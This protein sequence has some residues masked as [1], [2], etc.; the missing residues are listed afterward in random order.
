M[1]ELINQHLVSLDTY[2]GSSTDQVIDALAAL[3][4]R[5]G[6]ASDA[7]ALGAD[8]KAREAKTATGVP[9]GIAIPHCRSAAVTAPTLAMARLAPAVDF[10]AKDGPADLVFFIAAPEGADKD[11]LKLLPTLARVLVKKSFTTALREARE[12]GQVV[13][14]IDGVLSGTPAPESTRRADPTNPQHRTGSRWRPAGVRRTHRSG[15][16]LPHGHRPHLYGRRFARTGRR[17]DGGGLRG[18]NPGILRL[19]GPG[20]AGH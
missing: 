10:G 5:Q 9:G 8:A 1:T 16:R 13:E 17:G 20:P 12:P 2:L 6:R 3:V 4:A 18:G 15:H 19:H 7:V 14:L 11:H